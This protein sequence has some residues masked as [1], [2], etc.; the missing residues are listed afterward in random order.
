MQSKF[1]TWLMTVAFCIAAGISGTAAARDSAPG[2]GNA[3]C[4]SCH[5]GKKGKLE[6]PG[7]DDKK[8]ALTPVDRRKFATSVHSDVE[9]VV[10]HVEIIDSSIPHK[11]SLDEK[12]PDCAP[13]H[14]KLAEAAIQDKTAG[15]RRR[16]RIVAENIETYRSSSHAKPSQDD[17]SKAKAS[18]ND[19]HDVHSFDV[20]PRGTVARTEW[21]LGVSDL[22]G[23]CHEEHLADWSKSVHGREIKQK[24]NPKSADCADCHT[25]HNVVRPSSN[26]AKLAIT[27]SCGNCHEDAYNSYRAT[28]HGQVNTLG[29]TYTAKCFDCHSSHDIEPSSDPA[30]RMH[31]DNRLEACQTCHS[32][33]KEL[34]LATAGFV[35]FSP[36]GNSHDFAT[37]PE[38]WITTKFMIALLIGVFAFFWAHSVFW[39]YR[40]YMDR[41]QGRPH[42]HIRTHDLPPDLKIEDR[43]VE[44]ATKHVRRFG[45]MWRLAHLL[46]AL[47]VMTLVLTGMVPFYS[48]TAWAKTV[49]SW[50][51][52]P[53]IAALVHRTAAF[54]ML[55]IFF[56]HLIAVATN[57]VRNWK[58]FKFFGPDS[59]VPNWKDLEDIIGM[60]KWF[61]GKGPRP[62]IERWAYWE[63]FD[64]W[65]VFW[66]M[67]II[68]GSG[69]TLAFPHVVA[70]YLPGWVF[71][72]AAVVHGEEAFLA[73]VFLFTVH[74]FNNHFRP[75]K[76][77]PPDVVMFTG[78]QSLDEF[79]HEHTA[80]YQRLVE[81]GQLEKYLVAAP[82]AS[83]TL[84]SRILGLLLIAFGLSLLLLIAI[85]FFGG[86]HQ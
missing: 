59:F 24:H 54:T 28:Y 5:D 53:R 43:R 9:C 76:L 36:H 61:F 57:I 48:E 30:S 3:T 1:A 8:R 14:L 32:G 86:G 34:P 69:M 82:S 23:K 85:G 15:E 67:A 2:L 29:F 11:K 46:F 33:K 37:Y 12:K 47:S 50:L 16:M 65:A 66:G 21:H 70:H 55:G 52:G 18:C 62:A 80:Q 81:T 7:T 72:V 75:D 17:S 20:P 68:G 19:C 13:C 38:I 64:Y 4:L 79:R 31:M 39:W 78:T 42:W 63:K 25:A 84:V 83:F 6:V 45:R 10:C 49:V 41:K 56:I 73:A 40:E 26:N 44:H 71:N 27:A 58:D 60:F 77:P 74:F 51:G 35:S 22:C